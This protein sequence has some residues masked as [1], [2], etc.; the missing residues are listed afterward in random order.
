MK[1]S[2]PGARP[3]QKVVIVAGAG[4]AGLN[5]AKKLARQKE[6]YVVIVDQRNHH[7][8][9]P[10]LYQVA[11]AGLDPADIS[12]PIRGLFDGYENVAVHLGHIQ[13]VD[14]DLRAISFSNG[15]QL[16]Y[17]YLIL[18]CGACHSYFG[19]P[20][21]EEFAPGLKTLEQAIEIRRRTLL[22]FERAE[23]EVDPE[24]Q[25]AFLNFV[26]VGGGPTGVELAGAIS[27]ISRTVLI[28]DFR[29]INP[30]SAKVYLLQSGPR[31]LATFSE[32]LSKRATEDLTK[33][34]VEVRTHSRVEHIDDSGVRVGDEFIPSKTVLW[35]AGVQAAG[36]S[37]TLGVEI[38]KAG[39][40]KVGP[41]LS[42]PHHPK[43]FVIGD[44]VH[45]DLS[46]G[47]ILPGLAPAAI[48]TGIRAAE[49]II[50]D[51]HGK[52]RK[53]FHYFDKGQM[54]TIGK[55]KAILEVKNF[56]MAGYPAWLA[57]AFIH[58]MYLVGFASRVSVFIKWI[59][60][61]LF[62]ERGSRLIL[63]ESWR[64]QPAP[65]KVLEKPRSDKKAA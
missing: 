29:R 59:W 38:D 7:L 32:Q 28:R 51:I 12:V 31:I 45:F 57:W 5:A 52:E 14:L 23:N 16:E 49:N 36:L 40:I 54:A 39:R 15:L 33:M 62:S 46:D 4:F 9:Q 21:W 43:V 60:S 58:I 2:H 20:Q 6:L 35:A 18:A 42:I 10:L 44:F 37:R 55:R 41:D 48:Q 17:D 30:A 26:V 47:K 50:A 61:Y 1:M 8:F 53:P 65:E 19:K 13:S 34:G 22:A 24:K 56:R 64:S 3:D 63:T 11:T 25:R 27:D